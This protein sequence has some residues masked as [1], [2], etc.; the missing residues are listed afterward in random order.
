VSTRLHGKI[1]SKAH[2]VLIELLEISETRR[3][4]KVELYKDVL[5]AIMPFQNPRYSVIIEISR[6]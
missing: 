3:P 5:K 6:S 4:W 1:G 2:E